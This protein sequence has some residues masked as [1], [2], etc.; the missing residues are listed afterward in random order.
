MEGWSMAFLSREKRKEV[1]AY[2]KIASHIG[3]DE[4]K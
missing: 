4:L 2:H 1:P 3:V